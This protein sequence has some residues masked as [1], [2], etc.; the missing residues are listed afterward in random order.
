MPNLEFT[1]WGKVAYRWQWA[2][3][4]RAMHEQMTS[5]GWKKAPAGWFAKG[6]YVHL[7]HIAVLDDDPLPI[8]PYYTTLT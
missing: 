3:T 5:S 8:K 7:N 2:T 4:M 6:K 1:I